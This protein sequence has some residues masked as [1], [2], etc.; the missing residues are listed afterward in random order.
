MSQRSDWLSSSQ[1]DQLSMAL[2]WKSVLQT[3]AS[4]WGHSPS[5]FDRPGHPHRRG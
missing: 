5:G 1:T 2:N 3:N 4:A